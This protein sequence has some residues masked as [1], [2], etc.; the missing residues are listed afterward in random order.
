M[1]ITRK[2]K[3]FDVLPLL[4]EERFN[5]LLDSVPCCKLKKD[6]LDMTIG[7][8]IEATRPEYVERM[9]KTRNA[10]KAFGQIKEL[11]RQ[12]DEV[13]E[14]LEKWQVKQT[15][16]EQRALV[17][18]LFPSNEERMLLDCLE[19]FNLT[20]IERVKGFRGLLIRAAVDVKL[21]E[22][23]ICVKNSLANAKYQRNYSALC[24]SSN[25]H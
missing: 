14:L 13:G 21:S 2:T 1:K 4:T 5:N 8:Y 15:A 7:E 18:V 11:K 22:Y 9:F 16:D 24:T 20:T 6:V 23:L 12:L 17:G 10:L 19:F 3:T 25:K